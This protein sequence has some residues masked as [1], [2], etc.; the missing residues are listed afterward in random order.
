MIEHFANERSSQL[1]STRLRK[2]QSRRFDAGG[3]G[4]VSGEV[5]FDDPNDTAQALQT[6]N[7]SSL[8]GSQITLEMDPKTQDGTKLVVSGIPAGMQWQELKK[9]FSSVGTVGA[10]LAGLVPLVWH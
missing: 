4:T 1:A 6:L 10:D 7:G 5:R 3:G 2:I 8:K 9:H